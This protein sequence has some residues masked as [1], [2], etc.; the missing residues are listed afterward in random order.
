MYKARF[1]RRGVELLSSVGLPL[2]PS[3]LVITNPEALWT[4]P[5]GFLWRLHYIGTVDQI[6]GHWWSVTLPLTRNSGRWNWKFQLSCHRID[7]PWQLSCV[8]RWL[9]G[10]PRHCISITKDNLSLS[11]E[12]SL[13]P[14]LCDPLDCS[15]PDSRPWDFSGKTSGVGCRFLLQGVFLTLESS[16]HLLHH[17][18][19]LHLLS[20]LGSPPYLCWEDSIYISYY[21]IQDCAPCKTEFLAYKRSNQ[22]I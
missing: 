17:R 4:L 6:I 8:L 2:S 19:I 12:S 18:H 14:A 20:H 9:Q 22:V 15:P 3:L 21:N 7:Y 13:C 10:T 5:F 16:L 11:C 1:E